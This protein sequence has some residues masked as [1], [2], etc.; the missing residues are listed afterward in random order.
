[1]I[2]PMFSASRFF[3]TLLTVTLLFGLADTLLQA[4]DGDD[5]GDAR[6][7]RPAALRQTHRHRLADARAAARCDQAWELDLTQDTA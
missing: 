7:V 5:H 4:H 2:A 1:M 6:S 3:G